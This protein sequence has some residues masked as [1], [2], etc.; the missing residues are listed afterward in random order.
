[1]SAGSARVRRRA[2][3]GLSAICGAWAKQASP[4]ASELCESMLVALARHGSEPD[5]GASGGAPHSS[6]IATQLALGHR[7]LRITPE[8][9]FEVQPLHLPGQIA[10]LAD[11][12]LDNRAELRE[13]LAIPDA[14]LATLPDSAVLLRAWLRWGPACL[15]H[16][17]GAFAFAIWEPGLERLFL[18]RDHAG[19]RPLYY[20]DSPDSLLFATTAR[21][22]RA[23]PGVSSE[24]DDRQ[25]VRDLVGLPPEY[26]H[27][28]FREI[29]EIAPGHCV[30]ADRGATV[31]RRYWDIHHLPPTRFRRDED[32]ADR[33]REIFDQAVGSR[34]RTTGAVA[35]ELSAGLDSGTV[36]ATAAHLLA[37]SGRELRAYTAVPCPNF[38]GI[39][40]PGYLADEGPAAAEVA[41]LYPNIRHHRIDSTGSD[42][43]RELERIYPLLDLP[44]AAAL[45]AVWSNLI[46]D[47]ARAAGVNVMLSGALGN[48]AVSY[49]GAD[50]LHTLFRRGKLLGTARTA[51]TL[52][53]LGLSSGRNAASLTAFSLLPWSLRRRL[54]PLVRS[55]DVTWSAAHPERARE[56]KA[57]DQF[58]RYLFLHGSHL[59]R[60]MEGQFQNNQYGDYN[61]AT[62]AGW[63]I[64]VR[65]PTAD[66]RVYEFCA[67]IPPEQFLAGNQGRSLVRRAMS[68]RLP[69]T[70]LARAERGMQASDWYESLSAIHDELAAEVERIAASPA[71]ARLLDLDRLRTALTDWPASPQQANRDSGFR[72]SAIPRGIAVGYFIRRTEAER[73]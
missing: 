26:P 46:Y 41:A 61:A 34:L 20:R 54:D 33:F 59:P 16:L 11:A 69:N 67:S 45:N 14:E 63:G 65:D 13:L 72:Q 57:L 71:A 30:V 17:S 64:D 28:R 53:R 40:P 31:H 27:S 50:I 24:L 4:N 56:Q 48:F 7:L 43:L 35:S 47:H 38:S 62:I 66:R 1:M 58:R 49:T 60:L 15:D 55:T 10:L 25:L 42:M 23:C 73:R 51:W 9:R 36:T 22:I 44:P 70:T 37:P 8:D 21:A 2:A 3:N 12:R 52:R 32:Y 68:G 18:A 39:T 19:E 5:S 6:R 29:R